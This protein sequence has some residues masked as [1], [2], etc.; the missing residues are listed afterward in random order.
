MLEFY[1]NKRSSPESPYLD[2]NPRLMIPLFFLNKCDKIVI[3][4]IHSL[5]S[6]ESVISSLL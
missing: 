1:R 3:I 4:A 6:V 2:T 5:F